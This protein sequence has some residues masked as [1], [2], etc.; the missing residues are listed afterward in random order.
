MRKTAIVT[1][2]SRG[3]GRAVAQKLALEGYELMISSRN[4]KE[5][6]EETA[7][8]FR[9]RFQVPVHTY[10]G[11]MGDLRQVKEMFAS[12]QEKT[13]HLDLLVNNAGISKVGLFTE[14]SQ[15]SW[16]EILQAN[17]SSVFYCSQEAVKW[18]LKEKRGKIVNISSVWGN[19]GASCEV[20]YSASKSGINGLTKAL[21]KELAPSNIQVNA[22]ACGAI[23][24][25][26]N[27]FLEEEELE[28]L[29]QEIPAGRMGK[30]QEVAEFL[31][32]LIQGNE[33]LTGQILGFDGGWI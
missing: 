5:A 20:A 29:C 15:E 2:A 32:N 13:G 9:T 1:G 6:L 14:M 21:A 26:M 4:S 17:L 22:I 19:V 3:I 16:E 11:N 12:F 31:W 33:Y 24:T 7:L 30:P 18:M 28:M 25:S 10:N 8:E 27:Q 23:D